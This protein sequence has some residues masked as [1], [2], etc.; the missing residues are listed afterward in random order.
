MDMNLVWMYVYKLDEMIG[1]TFLALRGPFD[2][3]KAQGIQT[4]WI[5]RLPHGPT[6]FINLHTHAQI[7]HTCFFRP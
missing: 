7:K 2:D 1:R 4:V 3:Q 6:F 5:S